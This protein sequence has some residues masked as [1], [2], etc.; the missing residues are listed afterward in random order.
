[1]KLFALIASSALAGVLLAQ[2]PG[3]AGR[4]RFRVEAAELDGEW[5]CSIY[6]R[7]ADL[8]SLLTD[9][10]GRCGVTLE[11][12]DEL[13]AGARVVVD[14]RDRSVHQALEAVL[15]SVG[16]RALV[17]TN[18]WTITPSLR[19]PAPVED[20][21]AQA[22]GAYLATLRDFPGHPAG[23]DALLHQAE[24]ETKR[25]NLAAAYV[26]LDGL[27]ERFPDS[28]HVPEALF[29]SAR[30]LIARRDWEQAASRLADLLR[31]PGS[32]DYE[33]PARV[34]LAR[35]M[36]WL[37]ELDRALTMLDALDSI[38]VPADVRDEQRRLFVRARVHTLSRAFGQASALLDRATRASI[39]DEMLNEYLELRARTHEGLGEITQA[40]R[41]WL[42]LSDT[43]AGDERARALEHA[44]RLALESGDEVSVLMIHA[45]AEES[46]DS[47]QT[48]APAAQARRRLALDGDD[49]R[50]GESLEL[51]L[52]RAE[53]LVTE[54]LLGGALE[55]LGALD[56]EQEGLDQ[57]QLARFA[58]AYG[59][60]LAGAAH[61][62]DALALFRSVLPRLQ[63]EEHRRDVYL[64]AAE[65]LD[66]AG[67]LDDAIE[68]LQGR[69]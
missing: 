40:A 29:R 14:L 56:A 25:G 12:L 66:G 28:E 4:E 20:L 38:A 45:L 32:E 18:T 51:E 15:G 54:G 13:P 64:L 30:A 35:C 47:A 8:R 9:L 52:A 22:M 62:D 2:S 31:V 42:A 60:A 50:P 24:I 36:A 7:H 68:A 1:M 34:D 46:D 21:R 6:A 16:R 33:V 19:A 48:S 63:A 57:D 37:G 53:D 55:L 65:L 26:V 67:R 49:A 17:R 3:E 27:V 10:G 61:V 58:L 43:S 23:A 59:H 39:P 11:G 69:L 44:A 5:R 41:C